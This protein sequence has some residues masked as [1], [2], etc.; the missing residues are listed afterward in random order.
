M[1]ILMPKYNLINMHI[2]CTLEENLE[3]CHFTMRDISSQSLRLVMKSIHVYCKEIIKEW[4]I[5]SNSFLSLCIVVFSINIERTCF[6]FRIKAKSQ[7]T[8]S[9]CVTKVVS[10]S[11]QV[12]LT[13][14]EISISQFNMTIRIP[15]HGSYI[16]CQS[17][18]HEIQRTII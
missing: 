17:N 6:K 4:S 5:W 8:P 13:G 7:A 2:S 9:T 15:I 16:F 11:S 1:N 14:W 10:I 3:I 12:V 18:L